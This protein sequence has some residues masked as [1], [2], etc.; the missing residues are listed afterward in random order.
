MRLGHQR[1]ASAR[2]AFDDPQLPERARALEAIGED[3]ATSSRSASLPPGF[4]NAA[5]R[6]CQSSEKR[7]SSTQIGWP[8]IGMRMSRCR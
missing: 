1:E 8:L 6:R 2:E 4:G 5:R 3:A 7:A